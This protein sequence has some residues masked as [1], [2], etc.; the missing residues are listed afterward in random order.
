MSAM[1][2]N[3]PP[4]DPA[5]SRRVRRLGVLAASVAALVGA[6]ACQPQPQIL[7]PAPGRVH[8]IVTHQGQ[9][10]D[11]HLSIGRQGS[12]RSAQTGPDGE[13]MVTLPSGSWQVAAAAPGRATS[14]PLCHHQLVSQPDPQV[15]IVSGQTATLTIELEESPV[16]VCE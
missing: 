4:N 9:P 12:F 8:A 14:D 1:S 16:V 11:A 6:A 15:T 13:A 10:V 2:P 3:T 5:T 7:T